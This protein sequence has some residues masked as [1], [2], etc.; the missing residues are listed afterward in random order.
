M[1]TG[2]GG[3]ETNFNTPAS[4]LQYPIPPRPQTCPAPTCE[5]SKIQITYIYKTKNLFKQKKNYLLVS[6]SE[7]KFEFF[8]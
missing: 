4:V 1:A 3:A 8:I 5:K 2:R 6:R 7:T